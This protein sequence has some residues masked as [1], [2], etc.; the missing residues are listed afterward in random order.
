[1]AI[2]GIEIHSEEKNEYIMEEEITLALEFVLESRREQNSRKRSHWIRIGNFKI[3]I[4]LGVEFVARRKLNSKWRSHWISIGNFKIS[5][6]L[7]LDFE[8]I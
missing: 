3:I 5:I 2:F 7:E 8:S 6:A 4:A 1:M